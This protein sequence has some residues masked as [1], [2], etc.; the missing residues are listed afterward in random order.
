MQII[1]M[2]ITYQ[3]VYQFTHNDLHTNNVMYV[4][5]DAVYL[6]YR[7]NNTNYKVPTFGKVFKII[8]FGRAIYT[9]NGRKY[10]SDSFGPQGDASC[11]YNTE[12][13]VTPS[14]PVLDPNPSFDLC[15]LAC[16]M[17]DTLPNTPPYKNLN[18]LIHEWCC[19]DKGRNVMFKRSGEERYP[20]FKLYKMIARTVHNHLPADQLK[21]PMFAKYAAKRSNPS[22]MNIDLF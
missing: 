10:V 12:P 7:F 11:Q 13:F 6:Y 8:D 14:K 1:M 16:S 4:P 5:T 20:N 21:R 3:K 9:F 15:R 22:V 18:A 19:D 17:I 2:L